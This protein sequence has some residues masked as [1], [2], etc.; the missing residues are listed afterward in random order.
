MAAAE[1]E[2]R[3][4]FHVVYK[5]PAGDGLYVWA[6]NAQ[7]VEKKPEKAIALFWASLE[8]GDRVDSALKDLAIVL[9]Q[10]NR[11]HDA[12]HAICIFRSRCSESSKTPLTT[13]S[14][15]SISSG[16][17][18]D[19]IA[20]LIRK[21]LAFQNSQSFN[22]RRTKTAR[23]Q[24]KKFQISVEQEVAR[25]WGNL[26]W[27][28]MQQFNYKDAESA[29]RRALALEV[30]GN[31]VCNLGVCLMKQGKAKEALTVLQGA[32][33]SSNKQAMSSSRLKSYKQAQ[34][35]ISQASAMLMAN[36]SVV[37]LDRRT[38]LSSASLLNEGVHAQS[39]CKE[40]CANRSNMRVSLEGN[41]SDAC[42]H[43]S[44]TN[45]VDAVKVSERG[46]GAND[47]YN[48]R[49]ATGHTCENS[50]ESHHLGTYNMEESTTVPLHNA[51]VLTMPSLNSLLKL[52]P[53]ARQR[54]PVFRD[55]TLIGSAAA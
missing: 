54:L 5:V 26:G 2:G 7:L 32:S 13:F 34:E 40:A 17:L 47:Q 4:P 11:P 38:A 28:Y 14:L 44:T 52:Q 25:L 48:D 33:L 1:E 51:P 18:D 16:R 24:G 39:H 23:S 30:D 8:A 3:T 29:Y 15:I 6:K 41:F 9:K 20:L 45:D 43:F 22:G 50:Q 49:M 21:L 53:H 12:I 35:L 37:T 36:G 31:K 27:A 10:Q 55:I 42:A 19:Q 46:A